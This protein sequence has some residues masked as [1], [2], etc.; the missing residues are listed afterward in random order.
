[1]VGEEVESDQINFEWPEFK[2]LD[3]LGEPEFIRLRS[4]YF[5]SINEDY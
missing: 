3:M 5:M 4:F 2:D 1:M